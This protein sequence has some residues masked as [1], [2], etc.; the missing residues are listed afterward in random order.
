M[1]K[2]CIPPCYV[3]ARDMHFITRYLGMSDLINHRICKFAR[4]ENLH[5]KKNWRTIMSAADFYIDK[6]IE[7]YILFTERVAHREHMEDMF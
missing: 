1:T 6:D 2:F 4:M 7:T 3:K 5:W